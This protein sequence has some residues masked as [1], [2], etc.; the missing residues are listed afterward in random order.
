MKPGKIL[1]VEDEAAIRWLI[2]DLLAEAGFEI[3]EFDRGE[4][5]LPLL[6][7]IRPH[8]LLTDINMPGRVDGIALADSARMIHPAL[9]VIFITGRP[10]AAVRA[11]KLPGPSEVLLKPFA[12]SNLL[13]TLRRLVGEAQLNG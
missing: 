10:E 7:K 8:L 12:F 4:A 13:T 1:V 11:R 6:D 3:V 2:V 5:A 9:P